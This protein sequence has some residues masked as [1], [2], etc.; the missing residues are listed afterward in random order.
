[1][2]KTKAKVEKLCKLN[3]Q[4]VACIE[5]EMAKGVDCVDTKEAGE[6]ID[7]IKDLADAEKNL[8]KACYYKKIVEAME[9]EKQ[10]EEAMFKMIAMESMEEG[11][12]NPHM[13]GRMGYNPNRGVSGRY[14]R[15]GG[16]RSGGRMGYPTDYRTGPMPNAP[17]RDVS[18]NPGY[19]YYPYDDGMNGEHHAEEQKYGKPY[20]DYKVYRRNY[21]ATKSPEDKMEMD[22]YAMEH[23]HDTIDT[24]K[25][26]WK[27]SDP[28]LKRKMKADLSKLVSDMN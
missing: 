6:V 19:P 8:W 15:S 27:E 12:E 23:V 11:R 21:T 26:I 4:L 18:R 16:N 9:E 10:D 24:M 7:M 28:E 17:A 5:A 22:R 13:D 1:M 3:E 2:H 25:D 14:T 20:N